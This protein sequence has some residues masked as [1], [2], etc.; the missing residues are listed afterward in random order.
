M[1]EIGSYEGAS[2]T[3]LIEKIGIHRDL[4]NLVSLSPSICCCLFPISS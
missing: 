4:E 1:L 3:Y 2:T